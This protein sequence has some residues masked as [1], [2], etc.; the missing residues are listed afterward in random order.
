MQAAGRQVGKQPRLEEVKLIFVELENQFLMCRWRSSWEL[1]PAFM[2]YKRFRQPKTRFP[3][4]INMHV[5]NV[6][7]ARII[8]L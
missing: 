8:S 3:Y 6:K 7:Q 4:L 5:I 2:P 1:L